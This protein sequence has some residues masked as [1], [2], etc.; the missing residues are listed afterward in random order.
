MNFITLIN[1]DF[2]FE[3]EKAHSWQRYTI[4]RQ[5]ITLG[6]KIDLNRILEIAVV[7]KS[8]HVLVTESYMLVR[9]SGVNCS[10]FTKVLV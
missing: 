5:N 9:T 3:T 7:P 2:F 8:K 10:T 4:N 1:F 6:P